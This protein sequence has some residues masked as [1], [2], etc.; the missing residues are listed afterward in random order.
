MHH[1][2]PDNLNREIWAH[3]LYKPPVPQADMS[4]EDDR[5]AEWATI[6]Q[7]MYYDSRFET[8]EDLPVIAEAKAKEISKV[9]SRDKGK[10][11]VTKSPEV[12]YLWLFPFTWNSSP[13]NN[14]ATGNHEG[15]SVDLADVDM[16]DGNQL[17]AAE[18]GK[19][20]KSWN[21]M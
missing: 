17:H 14:D 4:A 13:P 16:L 18:L 15:G 9:R 21:I 6:A 12:K 7:S 2:D 1:L 5:N 20:H 11:V 3:A 10:C 8:N 19:T